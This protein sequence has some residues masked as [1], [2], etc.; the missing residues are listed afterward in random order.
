MP[1]MP[2]NAPTAPGGGSGSARPLRDACRVGP[3]WRMNRRDFL[4]LT[5]SMAVVPAVGALPLAQALPA[6]RVRARDLGIVT[7]ELAPGPL[8]A[9]TDVEGVLVGHSTI[10]R[11]SGALKK[12]EG[13]VRTGVTAVLP[14]KD[15]W[16]APVLGATH[17]LN[18]DGELT[19]VHWVRDLETIAQPVL[20]TN[21]GVGRHGPRGRHRVRRREARRRQL[22]AGG[23]R[24]LGW[25]AQRHRRVP[26]EARARV[27][28][29]R[30]R[31]CRARSPK[32]TSAAARAWSATASR[33]ASAR[34]RAGWPAS[35][36]GFTVGVLLQANFGR[37][38]T[39]MIGGVP[40][41]REIPLARRG[42]RSRSAGAG[43]RRLGHR[44]HRH[45]RAGVVPSA[46]TD[47]A[48]R[49]PGPGANR[50]VVGQRQRRHLRGVLD[51]E[52]VRARR[53][54]ARS[55]PSAGT[56]RRTWTRCF[57]RRSRPSK[58][59]C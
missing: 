52:P 32:A 8:N 18:G 26:R 55:A 45:R 20:I 6:G 34:R 16:R 25:P 11:G 44:R 51:G 22:P 59:R 5:A 29:H 30:R 31:I 4:D 28:G 35:A 24:D 7:G 58:R 50:H 46:R 53:R 13:P 21:T 19:G 37:R 2:V 27:R 9:I 23:R 56:T 36:G 48:P 49:D 12:G 33:A 47:V 10:V 40:V 1:L 42:R 3:R 17:T 38:S 15:V 41:G 57:W 14:H 43:A 54:G 39:L